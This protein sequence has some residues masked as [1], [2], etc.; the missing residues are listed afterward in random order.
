[1]RAVSKSVSF[2]LDTEEWKELARRAEAVKQ[3]PG[4]YARAA[5]LGDLQ[6]NAEV[7][8]EGVREVMN[9]LADTLAVLGQKI[10]RLNG[11]LR[12]TLVTL[13]VEISKPT[14]TQEAEEL[15]HDLVPPLEDVNDA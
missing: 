10:S 6:G 11:H 12:K 8:L 1:M 13:L 4:G 7:Q 14:D 15:A 5:L 2:R 3:S 9:G